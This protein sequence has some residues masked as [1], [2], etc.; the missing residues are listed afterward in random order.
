MQY[1]PYLATAAVNVTESIDVLLL[2]LLTVDP[3][4][5]LLLLLLYC[6]DKR[7]YFQTEVI[8]NHV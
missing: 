7:W 6:L 8:D 2:L 1:Y 5:E 4:I 3:N